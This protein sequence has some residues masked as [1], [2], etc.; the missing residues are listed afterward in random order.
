MAKL[1]WLATIGK[2]ILKGIS[3]A[4]AIAQGVDPL[5]QNTTIGKDINTVTSELGSIGNVVTIVESTANAISTAAGTGAQKLQAALPYVSS[6]IQASELL[7]GKQIQDEAG[8]ENGCTQIISGVVTILNSLKA[9]S[10][11]S[12]PATPPPPATPAVK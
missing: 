2:D 9:Q 7:A 11:Q 4:T 12:T 5:V 8:F 1:G 10:Q 6:L 3:I